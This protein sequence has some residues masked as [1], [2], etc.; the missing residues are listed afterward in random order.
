MTRNGLPG[1]LRRLGYAWNLHDPYAE[2][3]G[4][5]PYIPGAGRVGAIPPDKLNPR[6]EPP[7]YAGHP[8]FHP[9]WS[10]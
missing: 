6:V 8:D 1:L 7:E 9:D 4:E 10:A 5:P 3:S 2:D